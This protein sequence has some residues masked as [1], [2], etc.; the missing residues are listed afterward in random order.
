M[1]CVLMARLYGMGELGAVLGLAKSSPTGLVD[2]TGPGRRPAGVDGLGGP[3]VAGRHRTGGRRWI[4]AAAS[5]FS[6]ASSA[7]TAGGGARPARGPDT[8]PTGSATATA[9]PGRSSTR[10]PRRWAGS[11]AACV[12][13]STCRAASP[14]A[15]RP[16]PR[17]P[18]DRWV[19]RP[20]GGGADRGR[21]GARRRRIHAVRPGRRHCGRHDARPMGHRGRAGGPRSGRVA[22]FGGA[23]ATTFVRAGADVNPAPHRCG[24]GPAGG[25]VVLVNA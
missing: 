15:R 5:S 22:T 17:R 19:G 10:P 1:L 21:P 3:E 2:R 14:T 4:P 20:M 23:R 12:P 24:G 18:L 8:P 16:R 25:I 9:P 6:R 7:R 11:R 13:S